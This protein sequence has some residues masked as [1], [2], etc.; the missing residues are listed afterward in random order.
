MLGKVDLAIPVF[1]AVCR[2]AM[3]VRVYVC[4]CGGLWRRQLP[5]KPHVRGTPAS[6]DWQ[7]ARARGASRAHWESNAAA[8]VAAGRALALARVPAEGYAGRHPALARHAN[9]WQV[10]FDVD[11]D[12]LRYAASAG[13]SAAGGGRCGL[14]RAA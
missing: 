9:A 8:D 10:I 6:L 4:I 2:V 5:P 13:R 11:V 1:C 7:A 12:V 3:L 14:A